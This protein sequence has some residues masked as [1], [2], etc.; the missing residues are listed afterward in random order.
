MAFIRRI[1]KGNSVYLAKVE[2]YREAGSVKQRVLEYI[3]KE[4]DGKPVEKV[5][6]QKVNVSSVKRY[7]DIEILHQLATELG[8][9]SM[10]GV[11]FKPIFALIYAHLLH[12]SSINRLPT[13]FEQTAV[14]E[15]LSCNPFSTKDLYESLSELENVDFEKI[16]KHLIAFWKKVDPRDHKSVVLDVTDTYFSGSTADCKPRRGKDGNVSKLLQ[17]ALIVSFKNGFPLLHKTFEGNV[18]NV[19]IFQDMLKSVAD[20]GLRGIILDR[21]FFSKENI[22]S[23]KKLGMNMIVGVRQ[24]SLI[25]KN[26]L[27]KI[28]RDKI[29]NQRNQVILK[30]TIV[31]INAFRYLGG[32]LIV[33]YNPTLEVLKR[34]KIL[35]DGEERKN[36]QYVG[37]SLIYHTTKCGTNEVVRKYFEKDVVER[38]FKTLKVPLALRPIRVWLRRHVESHV[39]L[40]YLAMS[41]LSLLDYRSRKISITGTEA[42]KKM[43]Q[44]YRVNLKH[45]ETKKEWVKVVTMEKSQKELLKVLDCSV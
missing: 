13:W 1:K 8:L 21:G 44:I 39:K 4:V 29:Y 23:L 40:C 15:I 16:E 3:G 42:L 14:Y 34:D 45:A 37:Y 35:A 27:D 17:I 22:Q 18:S 32:E 20:N 7:L 11:H 33:I 31:Y 24:T 5:D 41:I 38:A 10:L 30:A 2:S 26:Y 43:Q 36:I 25:Q 19:K 9:P 6:I 28:H 12:K